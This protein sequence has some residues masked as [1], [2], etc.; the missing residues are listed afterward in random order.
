MYIFPLPVDSPPTLSHPSRW[1]QSLS[2]YSLGRAANFHCLSGL[3]TVV[4]LLPCFSLQSSRPLLPLPQPVSLSLF[5]TTSVSFF[6]DS[7]FFDS[8]S[9]RTIPGK[10]AHLL[11]GSLL[12]PVLF[13]TSPWRQACSQARGCFCQTLALVSPVGGFVPPQELPHKISWESH[14]LFQEVGWTG[15]LPWTQFCGWREIHMMG[16]QV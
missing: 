9:S 10:S 11:W 6:S 4:R 8:S 15:F 7:F 5:S 1:L 16:A 13:A 14:V 12:R 3:H 2:L